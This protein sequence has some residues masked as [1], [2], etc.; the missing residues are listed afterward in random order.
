VDFGHPLSVVTPTLDGDVLG[1]LA[2]GE[3]KLTGR[4]LGKRVG[5][6]QEGVR[7]VLERLVGQG[8]VLRETAGRAHLHSLN[9]RHLAA[10]AIERLATLRPHLIQRLREAIA[11]WTIPPAAALLFGSVARGHAGERSDIDLLVIRDDRTDVETAGWRRQLEDLAENVT[12]MTGNDA[13]VLEYGSAEIA[14]PRRPDVVASAL[15]DGIPLF[16]S[17]ERA[18]QRDSRRRG[19]P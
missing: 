2:Q 15:K 14:R 1:V 12:A 13:R 9:R 11:A 7:R 16:G 19:K 18:R 5:A 3:L 6:S 10:P 17:L 4:E 8:I